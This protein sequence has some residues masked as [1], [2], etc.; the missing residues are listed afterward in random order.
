MIICKENPRAPQLKY[1]PD[2]PDFSLN[3]GPTRGQRREKA[4]AVVLR[5]GG[6]SAAASP[7]NLLKFSE[8]PPGPP[9]QRLGGPA[10]GLCRN[11]SA[12][13]SLDDADVTPVLAGSVESVAQDR[14]CG[15]HSVLQVTPGVCGEGT[16]CLLLPKFWGREKNQSWLF[17]E[18]YGSQ[19][20]HLL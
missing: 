17:S 3:V 11:L 20:N 14:S 18:L 19:E 5:C 6:T 16:I 12:S 7:G 15:K 9:N 10:R 4:R 2:S 8:C 1:F 13:W